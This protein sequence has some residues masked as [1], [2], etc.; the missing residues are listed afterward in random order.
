MQDM[1]GASRCVQAA[2]R[3]DAMD[4]MADRGL[5]AMRLKQGDFETARPLL[6]LALQ[7]Q[8]QDP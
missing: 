8:P 4:F 6:E 7:L 1:E 2:L 3:A 5:G